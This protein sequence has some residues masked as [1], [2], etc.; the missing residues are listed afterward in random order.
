[1]KVNRKIDDLFKEKIPRGES[2][3]PGEVWQNIS[4]RLSNPGQKRA[5]IIPLWYK[6]AGVAAL[7]VLIITLMLVYDQ[8]V[9]DDSPSVVAQ[10]DSPEKRGSGTNPDDEVLNEMFPG[11]L[12]PPAVTNAE[13]KTERNKEEYTTRVT[14]TEN[15]GNK[16]RS[17]IASPEVLHTES[18]TPLN[19]SITTGTLV[20]GSNK[21]YADSPE[22]QAESG[23]EDLMD[24]GV[25]EH[26]GKFSITPMVGAIYYGKMGNGNSLDDAFSNNSNP[27]KV[28]MAY[29][30]VLAYQ[31]SDK[32]K[33]RSGLNEVSLSS[34]TLDVDNVSAVNSAA[35]GGNPE[36]SMYIPAGRGTLNQEL[37]FLEIPLELEYALV[38][39]KLGINLI[40][41][42][43]TFFLQEN[44]VQLN[45]AVLRANLGPARNLNRTSYSAN[46]G[47]GVRYLFFPRFHFHLDPVFKYQL[48]TYEDVPNVK[49]YQIGVY[50][51]IRFAF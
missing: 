28:T 10:P 17:K 41:G 37:G 27:G 29:G 34:I 43:S 36:S 4:A 48:N 5:F 49:P 45:S 51:G 11:S 42:A 38:N 24:K 20:S 26:S 19:S 44:E 6:I 9:N 18:V 32:L 47:L 8:P 33:I 1:M 12:S 31:L 13:E 22:M 40:A 39:K 16:S 15:T 14:P 46:L 3:P 7:I 35:L 25:P 23:P 50:S 30:F 21:K 2:T